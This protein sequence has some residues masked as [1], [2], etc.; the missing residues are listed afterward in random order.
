MELGTFL[1]A[2]DRHTGN[3]SVDEEKSERIKRVTESF[4]RKARPFTTFN[5][6]SYFKFLLTLSI[7]SLQT[8]LPK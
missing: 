5:V 2:T 7:E 4:G 6:E 8:A 1:N 3:I